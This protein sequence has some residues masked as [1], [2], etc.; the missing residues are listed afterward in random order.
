MLRAVGIGCALV[1]LVL[2]LP[3]PAGAREPVQDFVDALCNRRWYDKAVEYLQG[4]AKNPSLAADV[5]QTLPY[6][7]GVVLAR[8]AAGMRDPSVRQKQLEFAREK[9][10]VFVKNAPAHALAGS[11]RNELATALVNIAAS[12]ILQAKQPGASPKLLAQAREMLKEAQ[13]LFSAAE[14]DFA[15]RL[16]QIPPQDEDP[17]LRDQRMQILGDL[18]QSRLMRAGVDGELAATFEPGT[19][20]FRRHLESAIKQYGKVYEDYRT[21]TAGLWAHLYEG[22]TYQ[23]LGDYK[24]AL[25]CYQDLTDLA[26]R[27]RDA[28]VN[29][30]LRRIKTQAYRLALECWTSSDEK[31][32]MAAIER[33]EQFFKDVSGTQEK[34]H[35]ALA[36]HYLTAL[37]YQGAAKALGNEKDP[38]YSKYASGARY[39]AERA[40]RVQNEFRD[41]AR[42]L[43][44]SIARTKP[45]DP[46]KEPLTFAD[47]LSRGKEALE[48]MQEADQG[49]A[50]ARDENDTQ[51]IQKLERVKAEQRDVA[52]KYLLL[53]L[54]LPDPDT[55]LEERN[56]VRYYL[57]Y[58]YW[59]LGKYYDA[60][61]LGEFLARKYP[62]SPDGRHGAMI[63]LNAYGQLYRAAQGADTTFES[64]HITQVAELVE[65]QWPNQPEAQQAAATL[66]AVAIQR[67]EFARALAYLDK[68]PADSPQRG[69]AE[70]TAG[71]ALWTAYLLA[72]RKP[73]AE[74]PKQNELDK[75][76]QQARQTLEAG[77]ARIQKEERVTFEMLTGVLSLAQ[78]YVE[79]GE[80][81][82]AVTLLEHPRTGPLKLVEAKSPIASKPPIPVETYK[83]ALRAYVGAQKTKAAEQTMKKLEKLVGQESKA[84]ENLTQIYISL[85]RSLQ[86]Q[87]KDLRD[88]GQQKQMQA[89]SRSFE[90]FLK[91][92]LDRSQGNTFNSLIWVADTFFSLGSGFDDPKDD[93]KELSPQAKQYYENAVKAYQRIVNTASTNPKFPPS[94]ESMIGVRLRLA[95]C[96][97]KLGMYDDAVKQIAEVLRLHPNSL[98][99]QIEG[100][101]AYQ[102][103]GKTDKLAYV[104]A[105]KGGEPDT[106]GK[107]LIWG[108]SRLGDMTSKNPKFESTFHQARLHMAE[109][110][111]LVGLQEPEDKRKPFAERA[112]KDLWLTYKVYPKLGGPE[113]AAA[114][115]ELLKKIQQTLGKPVNGLEEFKQ[116]DNATASAST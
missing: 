45:G 84:G 6:Y 89:V 69:R 98:A 80:S 111:Y 85:G 66:L 62:Q 79:V 40:T 2:C 51:T 15:Q 35:D 72:I 83:V 28:R 41:P 23:K 21:R 39:H 108:W 38:S 48:T 96:Q 7:Q 97:R 9:F 50:Q 93:P 29:K 17:S 43:L 44:A 64:D 22:Q 91:H 77:V 100:A 95:V 87:L 101:T 10:A 42:K 4:L 36:I 81:Q 54:R 92:I 8:E 103:K 37:A 47:A 20:D 52:L 58:I 57:S 90:T 76:R 16:T 116:R 114:Y 105:I 63:A 26:L 68:I 112:W 56:N 104:R 70:L 109:C 34:D 61:V 33:G 110:R 99:A 78:L 59:S 55:K 65:K 71:Q 60:A 86:Q 3:C 18:A 11:V 88:S 24:K 14:K 94:K 25:G 113:A 53:A 82:K 32:Y 102:A 115:E 74:R 46:E 30:Q 5:K 31:N 27:E 106:N 12:K 49:M 73:V 107:N 75:R 13:N 19:S 1:A 67:G